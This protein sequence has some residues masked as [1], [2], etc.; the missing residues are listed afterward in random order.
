MNGWVHIRRVG[1][2]FGENRDFGIFSIPEKV[3][4]FYKFSFKI[5]NSIFSVD[6]FF[7]IYHVLTHLSIFDIL[8]V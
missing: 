2:I 1:R 8:D 5:E 3:I 6:D 7:G 4:K